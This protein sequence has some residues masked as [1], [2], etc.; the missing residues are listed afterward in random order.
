MTW[1][2]AKHGKPY[3]YLMSV[4]GDVDKQSCWS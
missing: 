4:A 3:L 2:L 1:Y